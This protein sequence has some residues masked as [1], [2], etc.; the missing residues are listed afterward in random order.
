MRRRPRAHAVSPGARV[1]SNM[2]RR[3]NTASRWAEIG[4]AATPDDLAILSQIY[5][6]QKDCK[7]SGSMGRQGDRRIPQ[8]GARPPR[9]ISTSS[10]CNC[11][12]DA[13]E[14]PGPWRPLLVDLIRL[15]NK[16]NYWNTLLRI[17]RQEEAGRPQHVDAVSRDVRHQFDDRGLGLHRKWPSL[18]GDSALPAEAQDGSREGD[19]QRAHQR[20]AKKKNAPRDC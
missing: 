19:E 3:P 17:E 5:F 2:R 18:L 20:S 9:K 15:T 14:H 16:T 1:I 7:S 10:N 4:A 8:G 11:A 12:S 13:G 6:L